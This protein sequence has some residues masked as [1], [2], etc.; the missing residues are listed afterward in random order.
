MARQNELDR[1]V[2]ILTK[3]YENAKRLKFVYNPI[4]WA[5][6]YTWKYFDKHRNRGEEVER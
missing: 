5:L 2:S 4:A 3:N 1:A 6:Y